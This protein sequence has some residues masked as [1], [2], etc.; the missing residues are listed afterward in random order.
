MA[1]KFDST[2]NVPTVMTFF[3]FFIGVGMAANAFD[4]RL[5]TVETKQIATD[6]SV[7]NLK[8]DLKDVKSDVVT[9]IRDL[10]HEVRGIR[11]DLLTEARKRP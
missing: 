2:I 6:A 9:A 1:L 7:S 11:D 8:A 3:G 4:N 10:E 5:T